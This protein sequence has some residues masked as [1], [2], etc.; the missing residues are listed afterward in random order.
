MHKKR[1]SIKAVAHVMV[2]MFMMTVIILIASSNK[3]NDGEVNGKMGNNIGKTA[4]EDVHNDDSGTTNTEVLETTEDVATDSNAYP[5][6]SGSIEESTTEATIE[7]TT[8]ATTT[9][10]VTT[11]EVT[12]EATTE[13]VEE[14]T[15]EVTYTY[16]GTKL[17]TV[18]GRNHFNG[19][20]ETFYNLD[21]S[22]VVEYMRNEGFSED[23]YPYWVREDGC[24]MLGNY[25]IIASNLE[26]YPKGTLRE[27]SL[28]TGIVCDTGTFAKTKPEDVDIATNW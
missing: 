4:V 24:K 21:M 13:Y 7:A 5:G 6:S 8:E 18:I 17:S 26:R 25:I 2:V 22:L 27:T 19:H 28:G 9:E 10:E 11:E 1:K 12:T 3:H 15:T 23:E 20:D 16:E 14:P